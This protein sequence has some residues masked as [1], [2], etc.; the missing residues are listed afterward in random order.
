MD[1]FLDATLLAFPVASAHQCPLEMKGPGEGIAEPK[2]GGLGAGS[3]EG[4]G[5]LLHDGGSDTHLPT[6][7]PLLPWHSSAAVGRLQAVSRRLCTELENE[8]DLQVKILAALK[9]SE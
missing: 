5:D 8:R 3:L 4:A 7:F 2:W 9:E 1:T 6:L